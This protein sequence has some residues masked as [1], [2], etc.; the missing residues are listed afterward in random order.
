MQ[1]LFLSESAFSATERTGLPRGDEC[2]THGR[3][4]RCDVFLR[5]TS[6]A[7]SSYNTAATINPA[8]IHVRPAATADIF[9]TS[10][11][12]ALLK[13]RVSFNLGSPTYLS[14]IGRTLRGNRV[15]HNL[16]RISIKAFKCAE[17]LQM[18]FGYVMRRANSLGKWNK[19]HVEDSFRWVV[20]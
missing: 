17:E 3:R 13:Q 20:L 1:L 5:L 7:R 18:K 4:T 8:L 6:P 14:L 16:I 19:Q 12:H 11:S 2:E 9:S 15:A 10:S